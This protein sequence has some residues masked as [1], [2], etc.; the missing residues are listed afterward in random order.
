[1]NL[2]RDLFHRLRL[3]RG[4]V[5]AQFA[6]TL[7]LILLGFVW[8]NLPDEHVWQVALILLIVVL[9]GIS[10][11]ELQAGTMRGL[12]YDDGKRVKLVWGALTLL[13]WIAMA[14]AFWA[15]LDWCDFQIPQW[16]GYLSAQAPAGARVSLFSFVHIYVGLQCVEWVLRW[17]VLPA[18][19][20]PYGIASAQ[21]GW[22]LPVRRI[23]RLLWNW[24]WWLGVVLA[25]LVG[26]GLPSEFF[27][28]APRGTV[29]AQEWHVGLKLAGA[30]LLAV[31]SWVLLLGWWAVLFVKREAPPADVALV[32]VP[33]LAG[34][35]ES[36]LRAKAAPPEDGESAG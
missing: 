14:C 15:V 5:V 17:V 29:A 32:A 10:A 11:L 7:G 13:V 4:W 34:P 21:W 12:A 26:V 1:M 22:R 36:E 18:K 16:A 25:S 30:Y 8:T 35:P 28:A 33:I 23:L 27:I 19:C 2:L 31:S 24:R 3:A 6:V 9:L 20:I